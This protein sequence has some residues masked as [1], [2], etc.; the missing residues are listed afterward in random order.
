MEEI[1]KNFPNMRTE[2]DVEI[3]E[4]YRIPNS[5][6]QNKTTTSHIIISIPEYS[7]IT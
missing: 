1:A 5:Q 4:A 6:T 2:T 3:S 7:F